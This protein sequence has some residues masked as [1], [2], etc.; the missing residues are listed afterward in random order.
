MIDDSYLSYAYRRIDKKDIPSVE[1]LLKVKIG[2]QLEEYI[3][4]YGFIAFGFIEFFGI[5]KKQMKNSDMIIKTQWLH[6]NFD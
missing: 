5:K 2:K 4:N 6:R 1:K 3:L